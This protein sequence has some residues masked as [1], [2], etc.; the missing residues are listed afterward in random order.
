MPNESKSTPLRDRLLAQQA[1]SPKLDQYRKEMT[2]MLEQMERKLRLEK[3]FVGS[4]WIFLVVTS[5]SMLLAGGQYID[6]PKGTWFAI[7]AC[8]W[9]LYGAVELLKHFMNRYRV[10]LLKEIKHVELEVRELREAI[11]SGHNGPT[12]G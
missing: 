3:W 5:V 11:T 9:L 6:S 8:I 2:A 1:A 7:M 10:E 4:L 12:A